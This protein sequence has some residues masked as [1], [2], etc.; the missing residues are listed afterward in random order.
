LVEAIVH[1][2]P[3]FCC[4]GVVTAS[5]FRRMQKDFGIPIVDIFYDGTANPNRI[6]IPHLHYLKHLP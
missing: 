5:L 4:P 2:N 1:V 3:L 6:L